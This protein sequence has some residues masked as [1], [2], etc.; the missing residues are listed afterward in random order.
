MKFTNTDLTTAVSE[1]TSA[2]Q[3]SLTNHHVLWLVSGGSCV[4]PQCE[5]LH[6]LRADSL[7][8]L[9]VMLVDERY[10]APLHTDSNYAK[11]VQAGFQRKGL[12][13]ADILSNNLSLQET[14]ENFSSALSNA[15]TSSDYVFATLGLGGDGHTAGILPNSPAVYDTISSAVGYEWSDFTRISAGL[16]V[17][18]RLDEAYVLA[19]GEA[20]HDAILRLQQG[21][22]L[23]EQLPALI[24]CDIG[25]VTVYND[26]IKSEGAT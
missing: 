16:S 6:A 5:I 3:N 1:V 2:L 24:L 4:E 12:N 9:T 18:S 20:K 19:F 10:G 7:P 17:L 11:L 26:S 23:I 14:V 22:E 8:N 25:S 21:N 15:L 13:F